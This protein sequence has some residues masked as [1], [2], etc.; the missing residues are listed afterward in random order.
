M[1]KSFVKR[2]L[3]LLIGI[4]GFPFFVMALI[5]FGPIIKATDEGPVFYSAKRVGKNGKLFTMYKFR[6]M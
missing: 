3:D 4:I 2:L 5:I 6:S 1:Y